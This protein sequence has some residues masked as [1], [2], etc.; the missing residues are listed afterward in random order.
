[1]RRK[2]LRRWGIRRK[3]RQV[4]RPPQPGRG[5]AAEGQAGRALL[6]LRGSDG[7]RPPYILSLP[8]EFHTAGIFCTLPPGDPHLGPKDEQQLPDWFLRKLG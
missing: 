6:L 2:P 1:M 8:D 5:L 3:S 7:D 4:R